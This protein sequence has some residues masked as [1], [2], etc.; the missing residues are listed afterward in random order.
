[1]NTFHGSKRGTDIWGGQGTGFPNCKSKSRKKKCDLISGLSQLPTKNRKP[2]QKASQRLK[3]KPGGRRNRKHEGDP[4]GDPLE[5][6]SGFR[7]LDH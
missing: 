7:H 2:A 4:E 3:K 6:F 5:K 1:M